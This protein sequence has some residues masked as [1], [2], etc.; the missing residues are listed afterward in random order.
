MSFSEL[1]TKI[2]WFAPL[3]LQA[4]IA[5]VMLRRRLAGVF[6]VFFGYTVLVLSRDTFLLFFQHKEN[7]YFLIYWWGEGLA[8]LLGLAVVLEVLRHVLPP[9]PFLKVVWVWIRI[10]GSIAAATAFLIL[11]LSKDG[12]GANRVLETI[13]LLERAARFLQVC[14]LVVVMALMS[15]L[16]LT[17]QHYTLG[18]VLG[19]GVFSA[20]DL[21]VLEF[22]AH[23]HI[24]G[25]ATFVLAR[26]AAYN[27]GAII[28]AGYF[29]LAPRR[30]PVGHV[31]RTDLAEW[32]DTVTDYVQQWYQR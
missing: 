19:F 17:W 20:L 23:L 22:W 7:L 14:L 21:A 30:I 6:P 5:S 24:V 16:G 10:L 2:L 9:Y 15:R 13:V 25:N 28:W 12:T 3:I 4:A 11:L 1:L 27:L 31:P 32:N 26:P 29:L 8:V 18:I